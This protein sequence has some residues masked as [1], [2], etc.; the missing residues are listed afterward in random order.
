MF[1]YRYCAV[2]R[3]YSCPTQFMFCYEL[4][5]FAT[6][7]NILIESIKTHI[8]LQQVLIEN[9]AQVNKLTSITCSSM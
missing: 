9:N 3:I 6:K 4:D 2:V 1:L 7:K 8:Y 5:S